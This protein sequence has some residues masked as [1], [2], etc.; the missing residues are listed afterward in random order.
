MKSRTS[1]NLFAAM[2]AG[3]SAWNSRRE[4]TTF[5][6]RRRPT[7]RDRDDAYQWPGNKPIRVRVLYPFSGERAR[8]CVNEKGKQRPYSRKEHGELA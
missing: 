6:Y 2:M 5:G 3:Y 7:R 1:R 8:E 4:G